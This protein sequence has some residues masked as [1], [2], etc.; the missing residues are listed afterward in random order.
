[1]NVIIKISVFIEK[2]IAN[3]MSGVVV[4]FGLFIAFSMVSGIVLRTFFDIQ[5][6]GLEELIL[7]AAMWVY[8]LGAAL[9]SREG[10]HL[11]A[12][13]FQTFSKN[14]SVKITIRLIVG[15][16]SVVMALY[17]VSWSY[18]LFSWG[19][20]RKQVTPVF[21]IPQYVSQVSLLV[22]SVLICLYGAR[23]L[24]RDVLKLLRIKFQ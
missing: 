23:D 15:L 19:F 20:Q 3:L 5:M 2:L 7:I 13:F 22:A 11:S 21:S 8:M 18:N 10:S 9:A 17:F 16:I 14:E 24:A 4:I 1:M 12:D 6:F